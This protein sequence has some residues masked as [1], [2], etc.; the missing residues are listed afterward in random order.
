MRTILI[1]GE[2]EPGLAREALRLVRERLCRGHADLARCPVCRRIAEGAHPDFLRIVPEGAAAAIKVEAVRDAIRFAAGKPYEA[3]ARVVWIEGAE[4]LREGSAAHALLK[5]LEEPGGLVTWILTTTAPAA[6]LPTIRSRCELRRQR[7]PTEAETRA[8]W[9]ARGLDVS[10][11]EDA[12]AFGLDPEG[13]ADLESARE[14]RRAAVE[15]LGA[16][17]V[18]PLLG[19][20]ATASDDEG[21][22]TL[23]SG[24]LRDAAVL[25]SGGPAERV[26]H[27]TV[28]SDLAA[29]ARRHPPDALRRAAIEVDALPDRFTRFVIKRLAWEDALLEL[30]RK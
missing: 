6:I 19:L 3:P 14:L 26:R 15:A 10:A 29:I 18:S 21:A 13:E 1:A 17:G 7:R 22:P 5:S 30:V 8:A 28:A 24:L 2:S 27:R 12:V 9:K 20:A 11:V 25:G 23:V 4:T 16:E